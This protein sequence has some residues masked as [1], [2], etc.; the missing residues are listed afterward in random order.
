MVNSKK[1]LEEFQA[2]IERMHDNMKTITADN[3][4]LKSHIEELENKI[5][6]DNNI[7]KEL[8]EENESVKQS[9]LNTNEALE[10]SKQQVQNLEQELEEKNADLFF[11]STSCLSF[12][13]VSWAEAVAFSRSSRSWPF[14]ATTLL[15][16][17]ISA[18][19]SSSSCSRF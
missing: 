13:M 17:S 3:E 15:F 9:L 8:R 16:F 2:Q 18:F 19:F 4:K 14:S 1:Q 12:I 5:A 7:E 6:E 11:S 10:A